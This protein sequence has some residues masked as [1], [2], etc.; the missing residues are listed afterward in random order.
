MSGFAHSIGTVTDTNTVASQF[1]EHYAAALVTRDE[2]AIAAMYAV[3]SLILFPGQSIL[4]TDP[5]QTEEF[6]A[7]S[8]SQYEGVDAADKQ[9]T[10]MGEGP[11][12]VWADV[13]WSY[14]GKPQERFCYQ[15]IAGPN[16]YQIAVLTPRAAAP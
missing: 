4:V 1:F 3:P 12:S 15:L 14:H 10:I 6:F 5:V 16:G 7:D 11:G 9:M 8:W 2:K 13:T